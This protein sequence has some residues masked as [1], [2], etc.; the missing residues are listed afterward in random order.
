MRTAIGVIALTS[1]RAVDEAA[2]SARDAQRAG[3]ESRDAL[4]ASLAGSGTL[5]QMAVR[6]AGADPRIGLR[7]RRLDVA[8]DATLLLKRL[9]AMDRRADSAWTR[10][11]LDVVHASP[12]IA[13]RLL[14]ERVSMD[15]DELKRRMR[16]LK[17]LGLTESLETGYRLSPR[18]QDARVLL[19]RAAEVIPPARVR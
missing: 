6:L 16:Q 12:G 13:A 18:G 2:I 8:S 17:E 10:A 11:L 3:F 9:R 14:A 5:Y 1:A 15:R 19:A 4:I 7:A